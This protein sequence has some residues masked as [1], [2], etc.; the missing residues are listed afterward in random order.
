MPVHNPGAPALA[1]DR[2]S[3]R[4]MK[5]YSEDKRVDKEW[6]LWG[7]DAVRKSRDDKMRG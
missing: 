7:K 6:G 3:W 2:P 4:T 5:D 1:T